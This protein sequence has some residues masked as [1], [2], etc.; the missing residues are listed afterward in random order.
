MEKNFVSSD[1]I[2]RFR[3]ELASSS[4][5]PG[6]VLGFA[7]P[8]DAVEEFLNLADTVTN[9]LTGVVQ[10]E[11]PPTEPW[12]GQTEAEEEKNEEKEAEKKEEE[13]A[14]MA[15]EGGEEE[16]RANAAEGVTNDED[17]WYYAPWKFAKD[18]RRLTHPPPDPTSGMTFWRGQ[19]LRKLSGKFAKRGGQ[20]VRLRQQRR[21]A[22]QAS[23]SSSWDTSGWGSRWTSWTWSSWEA[24]ETAWGGR[25][26]CRCIGL[27]RWCRLQCVGREVACL[28]MSWHGDSCCVRGW[29]KKRTAYK[30]HSI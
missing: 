27:A 9:A 20:Q 12:E 25:G 6:W 1:V 26:W 7:G 8:M 5:Q 22:T 29:K 14:T 18:G 13:K 2:R 10:Q 24:S 21:Q 3:L 16:Q 30:L 19:P 4:P 15:D 23:S 17:E 11:S 28:D